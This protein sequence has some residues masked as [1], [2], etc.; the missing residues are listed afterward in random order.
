M[1]PKTAETQGILLFFRLYLMSFSTLW[2]KSVL[3]LSGHRPICVALNVFRKSALP[4]PMHLYAASLNYPL[5]VSRILWLSTANPLVIS[6]KSKALHCRKIII[7]LQHLAKNYWV[8][9]KNLWPCGVNSS[10]LFTLLWEFHYSQTFRSLLRWDIAERHQI[11]CNKMFDAEFEFSY[12]WLSVL[13]IMC[14]YNYL[15]ILMFFFVKS[16]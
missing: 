5:Y 9:R 12:D 2:P 3:L 15:L 13:K 11:Q 4:Y 10:D 6:K 8:N 16:N 14:E 1:K 7:N